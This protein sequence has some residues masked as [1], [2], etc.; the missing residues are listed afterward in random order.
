VGLDVL[1]NKPDFGSIEARGQL[2]ERRVLYLDER[3]AHS[4]LL[5][6]FFFCCFRESA[7][8]PIHPPHPPATSTHPTTTNNNQPAWSHNPKHQIEEE[9][10]EL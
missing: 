3:E 2:R 1:R 9:K 7:H 4:F 5:L 8:P 6:L 10:T